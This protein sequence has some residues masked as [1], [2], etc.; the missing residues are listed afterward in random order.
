MSNPDY[1]ARLAESDLDDMVEKIVRAYDA[2]RT[3]S[4]LRERFSTFATEQKEHVD[5]LN[6]TVLSALAW[7]LIMGEEAGHD[8][9]VLDQIALQSAQRAIAIV[10]RGMKERQGEPF[11][12]A[13]VAIVAYAVAEDIGKI[14]DF[15]ADLPG[16]VATVETYDRSFSAENTR[17]RA[18]LERV[19]AILTVPAAEYVPAIPDAWQAID[20]ALADTG[21]PP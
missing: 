9:D 13:R 10:S 17:L 7:W 14:S 15:K 19:R 20:A 6:V 18:A 16:V 12:P 8:R 5:R 2:S 4:D 11:D 3:P 1:L 21:E